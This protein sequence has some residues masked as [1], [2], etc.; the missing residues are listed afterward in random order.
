MANLKMQCMNCN[1]Q[2]YKLKNFCSEFCT[3]FPGICSAADVLVSDVPGFF[4]SL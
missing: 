4:S 1:N 2:N 3:N